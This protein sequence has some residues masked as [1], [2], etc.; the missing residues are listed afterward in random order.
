V[1]A[2]RVGR[3]HGLDGSFH[4][5]E[6][7]PR[8]LDPDIPVTVDGRPARVTRLAGTDERPIVRLDLAGSREAAE[9]LRG[10]ALDVARADAPVLDEGEYWAEDL[11]GARVVAGDRELGVVRALVP[12]PSVEALELDGGDLVPMVRDAILSVD[13]AA[14][15]ITVDE[16]FLGAA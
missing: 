14:R 12:L 15:L 8:L 10:L 7:V 2:G 4:V 9:A 6:P 11:V 16:G 3:A 5:H 1:L 13:V